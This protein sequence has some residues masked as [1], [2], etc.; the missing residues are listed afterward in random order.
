MRFFFRPQCQTL[1]VA[2]TLRMTL[3]DVLGHPKNTSGEVPTGYPPK[4][5][6]HLHLIFVPPSAYE[7]WI[8]VWQLWLK[9]VYNFL[10]TFT[11]RMSLKEVRERPYFTSEGRSQRDFL[12]GYLDFLSYLK[13]YDGWRGRPCERLI[14][15]WVKGGRFTSLRWA[16]S[17]DD[18]FLSGLAQWEK[19]KPR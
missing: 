8:S 3:T 15:Q 5:L 2:L 7:K 16:T 12:G 4:F 13:G 14:V 19:D 17:C 9:Y 11:L 1:S 10:E 6:L 18:T